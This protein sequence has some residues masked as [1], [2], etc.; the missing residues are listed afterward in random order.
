[1]ADNASQGSTSGEPAKG[2]TGPFWALVHFLVLQYLRDDDDFRDTVR[3]VSVFGMFCASFGTTPWGI[4]YVQQHFTG[5]DPSAYSGEL[6]SGLTLLLYSVM[7]WI[8]YG[9]MR[10]SG[11]NLPLWVPQTLFFVTNILVVTCGMGSVTFPMEAAIMCVFSLG[12]GARLPVTEWILLVSGF[13]ICIYASARHVWPES[14]MPQPP[15]GFTPLEGFLCYCLSLA[16]YTVQVLYTVG[17]DYTFGGKVTHMSKA[18][19]DNSLAPTDADEP[20]AVMFTDIQS[21]THLWATV[22]EVMADA[23]ER[24]NVVIR[25][26]IAAH[27]G[28]EVKTVGDA[29]V[30]VYKSADDALAAALKIQEGLF[31]AQWGGNGAIDA[32]YRNISDFGDVAERPHF[33]DDTGAYAASWKGLRVRIGVHVGLCDIKFDAI[34]KGYDYFGG[35]MNTAARIEATCYGGQTCLSQAARQAITR[36]VPASSYVA[37]PLGGHELRGVPEP[38]TLTQYLPACLTRRRFPAMCT[39]LGP[40]AD[41]R[42]SVSSS[43]GTVFDDVSVDVSPAAAHFDVMLSAMPV[44]ERAPKLREFCRAWNV[45]WRKGRSFNAHLVRLG[46]KIDR[47]TAAKP[48]MRLRLPDVPRRSSTPNLT[49]D[50]D[51]CVDHVVAVRSAT[52]ATEETELHGIAY[53]ESQM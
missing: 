24:H 40:P 27:Q 22:P 43:D 16:P 34:T 10:S 39:T 36:A 37:A 5:D 28:Y 42:G 30:V 46:L 20:V 12:Y 21:S 53:L 11:G 41:D 32:A 33:P 8:M 13:F 35:T 19:R 51:A 4:F 25:E 50:D 26:A 14:V 18:Q 2:R 38:V 48:A 47:V 29:F 49:D 17:L 9:V 44:K 7:I 6:L 23:L 52:P 15:H 1:M 45:E 31:R 3:K